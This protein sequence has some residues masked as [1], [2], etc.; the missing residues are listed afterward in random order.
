[1]RDSFVAIRRRQNSQRD[2]WFLPNRIDLDDALS[3]FLDDK[4]GLGSNIFVALL[5]KAL[6]IENKKMSYSQYRRFLSLIVQRL[7]SAR[8]F[9]RSR[10]IFT[11]LLADGESGITCDDLEHLPKVVGVSVL[12]SEDMDMVKRSIDEHGGTLDINEF[13]ETM[14][15]LATEKKVRQLCEEKRTKDQN[16]R[17]VFA[18]HA[19]QGNVPDYDEPF[20]NVRAFKAASIHLGYAW[21]LDTIRDIQH[22][23]KQ[24][25]AG[26]PLPRHN[27]L[28]HAVLERLESGIW[29]WVVVLP[30]VA[31]ALRYDRRGAS[32]FGDVFVP[33]VLSSEV[34]VRAGC[35]CKITKSPR[36]FLV[37]NSHNAT[38]TVAS[39][40]DVVLVS[41]LLSGTPKDKRLLLVARFA[42]LV[43]LLPLAEQVLPLRSIWRVLSAKSFGKHNDVERGLV[44][45][46]RLR[47]TLDDFRRF[48]SVCKM[49][50]A[51]E[52]PIWPLS[53]YRLAFLKYD[54]NHGT[55]SGAVPI[56]DLKALVH[57]TGH[58][59]SPYQLAKMKEVLDDVSALIYFGDFVDAMSIVRDEKIESTMLACLE[60]QNKKASRTR[61]YVIKQFSF[62]IIGTLPTILGGLAKLATNLYVRLRLYP[63][64]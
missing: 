44:I 25:W 55:H 63:D 49:N 32:L 3:Q 54:Q 41:M 62:L 12:G 14:Y 9:M 46:S 2:S 13:V 52:R 18:D 58:W 29:H 27:G 33:I 34:F 5:M 50:E 11:E 42:R 4:V 8:D 10:L 22:A 47:V 7:A 35:F 48:A 30:L 38:D 61:I 40:L 39:V 1:M 16:V 6:R 36:Q 21:S 59:P 31:L 28:L 57:A 51:H 60:T 20:L 23:A 64:P 37:Y 56:S 43:R 45:K 26:K 15:F 24:R 19:Q 53:S 17:A